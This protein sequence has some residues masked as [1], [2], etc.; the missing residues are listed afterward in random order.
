VVP[1]AVSEPRAALQFGMQ[2][3]NDQR[4]FAAEQLF[5][6]AL[7]LYRSL[8]DGRGQVMALVNIAD[9]AL[10]L[11]EAQVALRQVQEA[12]RIA[13]RDGVAGFGGRLQLL[14]AQALRESGA[15]AEAR[16]AL[17]VLLEGSSEPTLR[18]AAVLE[19]A[20]LALESEDGA[21]A[22]LAQARAA[23]PGSASVERLEALSAQRA[24][25]ADGASGHLQRA[26]E[27]YR[28]DAYRPGIAAMHEALG[29]GA[30]KSAAVPQARD[31]Y[32][33]ALDVRLWLNDRVH[34]AAALRALAAMDD[35]GG[36]RARARQWRDLQAY[37]EGAAEPEWRIVQMKAATLR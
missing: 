5:V 3:Y 22:W 4:Y 31:H 7:G 9:C 18:S 20:R 16:A 34:G 10:V 28:R 33:R 32:E 8:D 12:E 24:G 1:A 6:K 36:N 14:K 15:M 23:A 26:L 35:A 2:S 13:G 19:R 27:L 30:L 17:D 37:L 29:A 25:D 11:G 21:G